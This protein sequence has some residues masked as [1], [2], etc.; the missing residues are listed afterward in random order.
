MPDPARISSASKMRRCSV[1]A[2]PVLC[3]LVLV[4]SCETTEIANAPPSVVED[5]RREVALITEREPEL[6]RMDRLPGGEA[7]PTGDVLD[8]ARTAREEAEQEGLAGW[9]EDALLYRCLAS[10]GV[11][12]TDEQAR[13]LA[14]WERSEEPG[15]RE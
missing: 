11:E 2:S 10:R 1:F 7:G 5:C 14:E 6:A 8:E 12:L 3:C 4:A 9:P 13:T 15:E